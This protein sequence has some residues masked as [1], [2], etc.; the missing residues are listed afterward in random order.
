MFL[1]FTFVLSTNGTAHLKQ[2]DMTK[3][4]EFVRLPPDCTYAVY[5]PENR[6]VNCGQLFRISNKYT[7]RAFSSVL[8]VNKELTIGLLNG[9]GW[10]EWV[11]VQL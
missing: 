2:K 8:Y 10:P 11:E 6:G 1:C 9:L 4:L 5:G 3:R 7:Y